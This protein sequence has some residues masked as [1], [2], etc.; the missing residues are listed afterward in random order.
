MISSYRTVTERIALNE[1]TCRRINESVDWE[2]GET[3]YAGLIGFLCECGDAAC[4]QTIEMTPREYE[5]VRADP[6]R[7]AL[8][9]DHAMPIAEDIVERH[10]RYTVVEKHGDVA[11]LAE[12]TDPRR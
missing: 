1:A 4:E 12:R 5:G 10:A 2:Y 6:R 7:F 11:H 3:D 8:I 9:A